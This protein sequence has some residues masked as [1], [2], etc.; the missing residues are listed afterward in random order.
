MHVSNIFILRL[1][2]LYKADTNN[3]C[4]LLRDDVVPLRFNSV[5]YGSQ[6]QTTNFNE[7][8]NKVCYTFNNISNLHN[9][10]KWWSSGSNF[11]ALITIELFWAYG[12]L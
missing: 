3:V 10:V 5:S 11:M 2:V 12:T 6:L 1:K 7:H 4:M 8:A 9:N